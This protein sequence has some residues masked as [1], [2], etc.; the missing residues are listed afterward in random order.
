M[1]KCHKT[2]LNIFS[3]VYT[4]KNKKKEKMGGGGG[5]TKKTKRIKS[6]F[7]INF[8]N[9]NIWHLKKCP[10][11]VNVSCYKDVYME[12]KTHWLRKKYLQSTGFEVC[13]HFSR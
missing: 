9:K 13:A 6:I 12:N 3:E 4:L 5:G 10:S 1:H 7:K 11:Q 2:N 8:I